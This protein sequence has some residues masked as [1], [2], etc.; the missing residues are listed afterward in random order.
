MG[1]CLRMLLV[2]WPAGAISQLAQMQCCRFKTGAYIKPH[3]SLAQAAA[4]WH[5]S[6][7]LAQSFCYARGTA[8]CYTAYR[9]HEL[10]RVLQVLQT[11]PLQSCCWHTLEVQGMPTAHASAVLAHVRRCLAGT[12]C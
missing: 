12:A 11:P 1:R 2:D 5:G 4:I 10:V 7:H 3:M 8:S 9:K 6:R